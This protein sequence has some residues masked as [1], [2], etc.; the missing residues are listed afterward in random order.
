MLM[1][2]HRDKYAAAKRSELF[3]THLL[4][5]QLHIWSSF[6]NFD[7]PESQMKAILVVLISHSECP[8]CDIS[9]S[10]NWMAF[11]PT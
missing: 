11:V 7:A 8:L 5:M 10:C 4:K 3:S 9:V 1:K 6:S 2:N